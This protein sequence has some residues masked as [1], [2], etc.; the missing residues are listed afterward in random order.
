MIRI[1]G[2][3]K[4]YFEVRPINW[5]EFIGIANSVSA[6]TTREM[7]T[8]Q[9]RAR[10]LKQVKS[11]DSGANELTFTAVELAALPPGIGKKLVKASSDVLD[12]EGEAVIVNDGDGIT[13]PIVVKLG[14]PLKMGEESITELEFFA[15]TFGDIETV[16]A[17]EERGTQS[18]ILIETVAK[19]ITSSLKLQALPSWASDS[20][21]VNDG[22]FIAQ[23]V[24]PRFLE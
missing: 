16:L 10:L 3:N 11:F 2:E 4:N 12:T 23:K 14:Q 22:S 24:L 19:P 5:K 13:T 1:D 9:Q 7:F 15:K 21:T 20:V 8:A 17:H 6:K 18:V